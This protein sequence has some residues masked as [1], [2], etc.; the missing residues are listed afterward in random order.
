VRR[1][2]GAATLVQDAEEWHVCLAK[3]PTLPQALRP[4]GLRLE[5]QRT[6]PLEELRADTLVELVER[7]R[8][9]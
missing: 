4:R 1:R 3:A 6:D 2:L 7:R 9:A 5:A 8:V